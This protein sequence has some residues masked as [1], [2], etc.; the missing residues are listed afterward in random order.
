LTTDTDAEAPGGVGVVLGV[1]EIG[2]ADAPASVGRAD[3]EAGDAWR[4]V[5]GE[6]VHPEAETTT[7][8]TTRGRRQLVTSSIVPAGRRARMSRR[9]GT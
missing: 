7:A 1:G 2:P 9:L 6:L 5:A 3:D 4:C 8:A